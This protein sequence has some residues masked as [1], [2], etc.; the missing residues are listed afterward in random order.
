MLVGPQPVKRHVDENKHRTTTSAGCLTNR[1]VANDAN[2][3]SLNMHT[4]TSLILSQ[5]V[6]SPH[7]AIGR[8]LLTSVDLLI[9]VGWEVSTLSGAQ[10]PGAPGPKPQA[11]NLEETSTSLYVL[12]KPI[13]ST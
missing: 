10:P 9:N 6:D 5:H 11:A 1:A 2:P 8:K 7:G 12:S 13:V 4:N 3:P